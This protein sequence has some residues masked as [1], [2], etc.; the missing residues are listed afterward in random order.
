MALSVLSGPPG[1]PWERPLAG[2]VDYYTVVSEALAGN[3]LGDPVTRPLYVYRAPGVGDAPVA[4][5]YVLQGF[6]NQLDKWLARSAFEPTIFERLDAL[7]CSEEVPPAVVVFVDAWTSLGGSQFLN[8]PATGR[9]HD[10]LVNEV[11]PFI[12]ARYPTGEGRRG[13]TGHSSG[14]YGALVTAMLAPGLFDAVAAH[15]PDALFE[16]CYLPIVPEAVRQIQYG[17]GGSLERFH[18]AFAARERFDYG[19]FGA[20]LELC[21]YAAA[22]SPKPDD[23]GGFELPFELATG[24]LVDEVWQRWLRWDPVRMVAHRAQ[25]L[26]GLRH[27]HLEAGRRDEAFL[28]LGATALSAELTRHGVAHTLELFDGGHGGLAYRYPAAIAGIVDA[29]SGAR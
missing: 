28:D 27:L 2:A 25:A 11:V 9:Y 6:T 5:V 19:R 13:I 26:R 17:F 1:P 29:L 3:A 4:S 20:T 18:S 23:R 24:R 15:A 10:Y 16:A 21:A 14:G 12:D 8:S 22:Y 7:F